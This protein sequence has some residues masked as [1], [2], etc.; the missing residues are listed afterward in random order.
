MI[1]K[2]TPHEP[3]EE[4]LSAEDALRDAEES[5]K[6]WQMWELKE[7]QR[8]L[9]ELPQSEYILLEEIANQQGKT[10]SELVRTLLESVLSALVPSLQATK[11]LKKA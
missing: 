11:T 10:V 5:E 9:I 6:R 2:I 3:E 4:L 8:I 7:R 1:N